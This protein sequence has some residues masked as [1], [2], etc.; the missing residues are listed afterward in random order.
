MKDA[1]SDGSQN[2]S[3]PLLKSI[4]MEREAKINNLSKELRRIQTENLCL[5]E[6]K[7]SLLSEN[8]ALKKEFEV[9]TFDKLRTKQDL[10]SFDPSSP[11]ILQ[12]QIVSLK[13]QVNDLQ[14]AN[15]SA[16]SEL[17]KADEEISQQRRDMSQ[18]KAEY[19]QKLEESQEEIKLLKEKIGQMTKRYIQ[20]ENYEQSMHKEISQLRSECRR[21]RILSHQLDE[22]NHHLKE[23]LWDSKRQQECLPVRTRF[24]TNGKNDGTTTC[25]WNNPF[26]KTFHPNNWQSRDHRTDAFRDDGTFS[27]CKAA[28]G[29]LN[30][31]EPWERK[32]E[33]RNASPISLESENTDVLIRGYHEDSPC[34]PSHV[35]ISGGVEE[36]QDL[37]D[38]EFCSVSQS[39]GNAAW[40][41]PHQSPKSTHPKTSSCTSSRSHALKPVLPRRPFAPKSVGDLK[42]G[43]LVKFSRPGGKISNGT[44]QYKGLLDGREDV[45]LGV[46]LEGSEVGKHDGSFQGKRYFLCKPNK[47]VFVNF[48]KVIM[49]WE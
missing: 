1:E 16:V 28:L 39:N 8:Q 18:L 12:R 9:M 21:L 17:A 43:N 33:E 6:E 46:E 7:Q 15:E 25:L 23:E 37:S 49:A 3:I 26:R 29:S 4:L 38:D 5:L 48:S 45:Y 13:N 42:V 19:S 22:E 32:Y 47:G 30:I 27:K 36:L 44:V 2:I 11:F 24:Q 10:N 34:K 41:P 35:D 20:P 31:K 40:N 14:E